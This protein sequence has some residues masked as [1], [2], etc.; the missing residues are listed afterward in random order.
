MQ[1][2]LV[3][4]FPAQ[5]PQDRLDEALFQTLLVTVAVNPLALHL[6]Q[7]RQAAQGVGRFVAEFPPLRLEPQPMFEPVA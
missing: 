7:L 1:E 5:L 2:G 3:L 4:E 6:P